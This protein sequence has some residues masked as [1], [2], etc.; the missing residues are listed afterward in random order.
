HRPRDRGGPA[1]PGQEVPRRVH[2]LPEALQRAG[3][4]RPRAPVRVRGFGGTQRDLRGRPAGPGLG[5]DRGRQRGEGPLPRPVPARAGPIYEAKGRADRR[6]E[7]I[8]WGTKEVFSLTSPA[9]AVHSGRANPNRVGGQASTT[10]ASR[11]A[12]RQPA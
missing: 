10:V 4:D 6:D 9:A 8:C 12:T 7:V 1:G 11:T 2:R 3:G 5:A